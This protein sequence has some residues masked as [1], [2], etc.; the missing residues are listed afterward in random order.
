MKFLQLIRHILRRSAPESFIKAYWRFNEWRGQLRF[1]KMSAEGAFTDIY[2]SKRWG[3]K[4][5]E[6]F[7]SGKGSHHSTVVKP[8]IEC[9]LSIIRE[10]D[11]PSTVVDI[12]SGDFHIGSQI[13]GFTEHYYACDIVKYLQEYNRTKF[14][15]KNVSFLHLNAVLDEWPKGDIVLIRQVLQHLSNSDI[16]VIIKK[17]KKYK[18][19]V[20]TEHV[21]FGNY[22]KNLDINVGFATRLLRGSG[23]DLLASPFNLIGFDA[24]LVCNV[25]QDNGLIQTTLLKSKD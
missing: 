2:S 23:V 7:Y 6:K 15:E 22:K 1:S 9:V 10:L 11:T 18:T 13:S 21:P 12:G 5:G 24:F 17:F 4:K 25:T 8:Y 16:M 20:V 14:K 19:I 3:S